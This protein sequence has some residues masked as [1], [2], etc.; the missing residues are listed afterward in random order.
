MSCRRGLF[1][2][3]LAP[4]LALGFGAAE[5]VH[6]S[7]Y[8]VFTQGASAL[9][10]GNAVAA[11]TDSPNT[12][13]YNP[14]LMTK[15]DG[16]Q[17]DIGTTMIYS[18]HDYNSPFPGLDSS[19]SSFFF[20]STIYA[21]HK[22]N[23]KAAA[24]IGIFN[25][26]G[27]GT[28]WD[29]NWQG[30]FLATKSYL[31]TFNFNPVVAYRVIPQLSVAAGL[32]VIYLDAKLQRKLP[33]TGTPTDPGFGQQF[34][35]DGT[36]VGFNVA[37]AYDITDDATIGV[38]YRSEVEVDIDGRSS[39]WAKFSPFDT[40]GHTSVR[41]PQQLTAGVSYRVIEP[42][43]V[44][45]GM[46]WEGWSSFRE[47]KITLDNG[48]FAP[49][50]ERNWHDTIGVNF[51]GTYKLNDKVALKAGYI[52]GENAVPNSTFDPSIPDSDTHIFCLGTDLNYQPFRIAL[53]YAWQHYVDRTKNNSVGFPIL[54]PHYADGEYQSD[55]HLFSLE[56]GYKF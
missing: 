8:A 26:F 23:D 35:G 47:L 37:A 54:P 21:T 36:G 17:L 40:K 41:L 30:R 7:G 55:A 27:L 10:Q 31:T 25:P 20:P 22:I 6:A 46:R 12:I 45:A 49:P 42:L 38:S 56:L 34:K 4:M 44:E 29:E 48:Q 50:S 19:N 51:G 28:E 39:T 5:T 9:G 43:I 2:V 13:F 3:L 16:T 18:T 53:A 14:A 11:H 24:G 32:D 15:L 33:T 52:Y 1:A